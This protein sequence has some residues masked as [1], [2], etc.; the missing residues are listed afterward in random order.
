MIIV[1][2]ES[3]QVTGSVK[4]RGALNKMLLMKEKE[5]GVLQRGIVAASSGNFAIACV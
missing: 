2:I 4:I 3:E 5:P 1:F